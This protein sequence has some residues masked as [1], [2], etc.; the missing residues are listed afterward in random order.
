M[1]LAGEGP[2]NRPGHGE[3]DP[4]AEEDC[5]LD[6]V[7]DA[8]SE[9]E[10]QVSAKLVIGVRHL[11]SDAIDGVVKLR[12]QS[13]LHLDQGVISGGIDP[14]DV[15]DDCPQL[16]T[17]RGHCTWEGGVPGRLHLRGIRAP[18]P[19]LPAS[20]DEEAAGLRSIAGNPEYDERKSSKLTESANDGEGD[21]QGDER[22]RGR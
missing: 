20:W 22:R 16:V 5:P 12:I 21:G 1:R 2:D 9:D 17:T 8:P 11:G 10:A 6:S 7:G 4:D 15:V 18:G 19:R 13:L 14:S 3:H